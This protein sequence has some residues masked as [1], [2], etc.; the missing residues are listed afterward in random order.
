MWERKSGGGSGLGRGLGDRWRDSGG[1]AD[2]TGRERTG[3]ANPGHLCSVGSPESPAEASKGSIVLRPFHKL[4]NFSP[5]QGGLTQ[6]T[7]SYEGPKFKQ[8]Q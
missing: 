8:Y 4:L 2:R 3:T 7:G 1:K 6:I 5:D